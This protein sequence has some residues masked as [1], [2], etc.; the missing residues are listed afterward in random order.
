[1]IQLLGS[2]DSKCVDMAAIGPEAA[3]LLYKTGMEAYKNSDFSTAVQTIQAALKF[4]PKHELAAQYLELAQ[5]RL[6][7]AEDK[8]VIQ[9]QKSFDAHNLTD[10]AIEFRKIA[11]F[12][13]AKLTPM[14]HQASEQYRKTLTNLVDSWNQACP[15]GD[16][17]EMMEIRK[18]I[19]DLLPDPNFGE[20]IRSHMML[21]T[22]PELKTEVQTELRPLVTSEAKPESRSIPM[23]GASTQC[24]QLD[25]RVAMIRVIAKSKVDPEI[26]REARPYLQGSAITVKIR[27]RIDEGGNVVSTDTPGGNPMFNNAVRNAVEHWKFSSA[28]DASGARC[29]DTEI[30]IVIGQQT[31]R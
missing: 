2:P 18:Q 24:L 4:S 1:M 17:A 16:S 5:G 19:T 28:M 26:P 6:Q 9:W 22:K 27:I 12:N 8:A 7:V 29:V 20:D 21:C 3:D 11:A 30:P 31:S 15:S 10:A 13:D 25:Y 23:T 14:L